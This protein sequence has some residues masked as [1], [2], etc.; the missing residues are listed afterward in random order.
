MNRLFLTGVLGL[1][2]S[3]VSA[4]VSNAAVYGDFSSP[5]GTVSF[6]DVRDI[7]GLYGEPTASGNSLDFSPN[8]FESECSASPGCPPAPHTVSDT[9]NFQ[10]D[11]D[12]GNFIDG[13]LLTEAGDTTLQSF[14]DA[15]AATTVVGD[16]FIDV[17]EINGAPVNNVNAAALMVFSQNGEYEST[18][19]GYGTHLWSGLLLL[20]ISQVISD[21]GE[22][23]QA[24][25][26]G[27][28]LSNTL[29]AFAASG[30]TAR[31]EKKDIDGLAITVIPEPGSA[32]LMGL[33]LAGLGSIQRRR[34]AH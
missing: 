4:S 11:A 30:A 3:T 7:N 12:A 23:G 27:V 21:A 33:G 28:S 31:I 29:T 17:L 22:V 14:L 10:I 34:P 15:F 16:V 13:L 32:L 19:E 9:L 24:T 8:T 6:L 2:L 20:D 26:V 25:L 1:A 18:D 5:T